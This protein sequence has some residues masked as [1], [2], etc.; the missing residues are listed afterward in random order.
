MI[1]QNREAMKAYFHKNTVI[2]WHCTNEKF[3]VQEYIKIHCDYSGKWDVEIERI[4]KAGETLIT[5]VQVL[6]KDKSMK[7]H[8]VSFIKLEDDM[9][10]DM[11]EYWADNREPPEWRLDLRIVICIKRRMFEQVD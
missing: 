6:S 1:S 11:D 3:N 7:F 8:T 9:I 10:S 5:F 2:R 4:E